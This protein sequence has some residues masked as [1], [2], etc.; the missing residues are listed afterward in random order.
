MK[1]IYKWTKNNVVGWF[2]VVIK[3]HN[4]WINQKLRTIIVFQKTELWRLA[5]GDR[6]RRSGKCGTIKNVGLENTGVEYTAPCSGWKMRHQIARVGNAGT[7]LWAGTQRQW[8]HLPP[9]VKPLIETL[10]I[11]VVVVFLAALSR[12]CST[13]VLHVSSARMI[14][15]WHSTCDSFVHLWV[16]FCGE[17]VAFV[18]VLATETRNELCNAV[19][20]W[21]MFSLTYWIDYNQLFAFINRFLK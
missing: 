16:P 11:L 8:L 2:V 21:Y 7:P 14:N 4:L 19:N 9:V 17:L 6:K 18:T 15:S 5:Q 10:V 20:Y 3:L 13:T 1:S 12:A